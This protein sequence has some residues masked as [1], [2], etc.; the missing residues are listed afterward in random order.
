MNFT[1]VRI[2]GNSFGFIFYWTVIDLGYCYIDSF[3]DPRVKKNK[4]RTYFSWKIT[5]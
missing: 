1:P 3:M 5:L 2:E 4:S